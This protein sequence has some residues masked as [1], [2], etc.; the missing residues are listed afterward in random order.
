MP[1]IRPQAIP[2]SCI[3]EQT[4]HHQVEDFKALQTPGSQ[5]Q[6]PQKALGRRQAVLQ[7]IM[8]LR[9]LLKQHIA[10]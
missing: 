1:N 2:T 4:W 3:K 7:T 5:Q 6:V 10:A 8:R 9:D